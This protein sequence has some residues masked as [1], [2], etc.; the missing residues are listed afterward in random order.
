MS[1]RQLVRQP[2]LC[3]RR[4]AC[5]FLTVVKGFATLQGRS[6][7]VFM[8]KT[9][10][11]PVLA[12]RLGLA[13]GGCLQR[14]TPA[15]PPLPDERQPLQSRSRASLTRMLSAARR[16]LIERGSDDFA[17]SDVSRVGRVSIGSIYHRFQSK[18][19]L[20]R[21]VHRQ[22]MEDLHHEQ[23]AMVEAVRADAKD[24]PSLLAMLIDA[25]AEFLKRNAGALRPMMACANKDDAI[26]AAG[27]ASHAEMR[28]LFISALMI[29]RSTIR[30]ASPREAADTCFKMIYAAIARDLGFEAAHIAADQAEWQDLK[31][32][33]FAMCTAFLMSPQPVSF[34][35]ALQSV[36]EKAAPAHIKAKRPPPG[37]ATPLRSRSLVR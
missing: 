18:E 35:E 10:F 32:S 20:L 22:L 24:L 11:L 3:R 7:R 1:R 34:I 19:E 28:D 8:V 14:N 26:A 37:E 9:V 5:N 27:K 36:G 15:L 30:H 12:L 2:L 21:A 13:P 33:L 29:Y 6:A 17:L 25:M 16:L 4:E 31:G 23:T